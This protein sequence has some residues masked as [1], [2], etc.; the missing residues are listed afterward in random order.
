MKKSRDIMLAG[1]GKHDLGGE[2]I[3]DIEILAL[4]SPHP[5]QCSEMIDLGNAIQRFIDRARIAGRTVHILH[6]GHGIFR[7]PDVENADAPATGK[8][9]GD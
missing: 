1:G 7:R 4:R 3:P 9:G 5:R 6:P 8:Q 2:T